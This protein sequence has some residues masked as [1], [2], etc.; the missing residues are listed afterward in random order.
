MHDDGGKH[1]RRRAGVL[2]WFA[3]S[4]DVAHYRR[5]IVRPPVALGP[6]CH[7]FLFNSMSGI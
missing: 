6:T 4:G 2:G 1:A 3:G 5:L 7:P